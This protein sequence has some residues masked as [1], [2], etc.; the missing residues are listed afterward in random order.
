MVA[1]LGGALFSSALIDG[2]RYCSTR[3]RNCSVL[4]GVARKVTGAARRA[5]NNENMESFEP[6]LTN[7]MEKGKRVLV[8]DDPVIDQ[9][10][11][12]DIID[13]FMEND[14]GDY[15]DRFEDNEDND[16]SLNDVDDLILDDIMFEENIDKEVEWQGYVNDD[17]IEIANS[18]TDHGLSSEEDFDSDLSS[19]NEDVDR[20]SNVFRESELSIHNLRLSKCLARKRTTGGPSTFKPPRPVKK[21]SIL[22]P[23]GPQNAKVEGLKVINK[24]GKKYV[25][26]SSLQSMA[27]FKGD[28]KDKI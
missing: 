26:V 18:S 22:I 20:R 28:E 14:N 8:E 4:L 6:S 25:T 24:G 7:E 10:E 2:A 12:D 13:N 9:T 11:L 17:Q 27:K 21:P 3:D 15:N 19:D 23:S 16:F 5:K 1:L